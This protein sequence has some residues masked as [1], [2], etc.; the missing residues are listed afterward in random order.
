M[1]RLQSARC[2]VRQTFSLSF[3]YYMMIKSAPVQR[4]TQTPSDGDAFS[5]WYKLV[6][7]PIGE[8]TTFANHMK[9][10]T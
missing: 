3:N 2:Q 8:K 10:T 6:E 9:R 7:S 1:N 4:C 5:F